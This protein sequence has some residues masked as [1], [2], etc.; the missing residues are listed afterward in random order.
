LPSDK[1]Y[2]GY[3]ELNFP[4]HNITDNW[5]FS[6]NPK[7]KSFPRDIWG[8]WYSYYRMMKSCAVSCEVPDSSNYFSFNNGIHLALNVPIN[9]VYL[10]AQQICKHKIHTESLKLGDDVLNLALIIHG[11]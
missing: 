4:D 3:S 7:T 9:L 11:D 5:D 1:I 2:Y 6:Y 10:K 8:K